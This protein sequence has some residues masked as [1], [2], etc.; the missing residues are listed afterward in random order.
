M[1]IKKFTEQDLEDF[2]VQELGDE[3]GIS[4]EGKKPKLIEWLEQNGVGS[5]PPKPQEPVMQPPI[6]PA[7]EVNPWLK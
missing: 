1:S 3:L 2:I 7:P 6:E 5:I 4:R